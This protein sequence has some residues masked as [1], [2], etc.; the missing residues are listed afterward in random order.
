MASDVKRSSRHLKK[1]CYLLS[2]QESFTTIRV[3]YIVT[4]FDGGLGDVSMD[5][6]LGLPKTQHNKDS[7]F[8]TVDHFSK[9]AHFIA[10]NKTNDATNIAELYFKEVTRLHGIPQLIV[11]DRDTKVLSHFWI[12]L[13]KKVG[14][15]LSCSNVCQ[16]QTDGQTKLQIKPLVHC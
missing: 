9:M 3:I 15:K 8:V 13:W 16:P 10:C 14:T 1:R 5:F 2:S 4:N 12:I 11:S 7:I 6:I